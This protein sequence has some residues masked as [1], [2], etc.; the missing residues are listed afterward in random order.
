LGMPMCATCHDVD[1]RGL[2]RKEGAK[3]LSVILDPAARS[4]LCS[5]F[6][7]EATQRLDEVPDV[8]TPS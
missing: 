8:G 7:S 4:Q 3:R 5:E 6:P 1:G 2:C